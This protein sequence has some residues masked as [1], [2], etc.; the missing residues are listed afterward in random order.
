VVKGRGLSV[1]EW[2]VLGMLS[3]GPATVG[4]LVAATLFQQPTLTKIVDRMAAAGLVGRA[5]DPADGRRVV[6]TLTEDGRRIADELVP[7]AKEHE[8]RVLGGYAPG[9]AE[10]LKAA[11]RTLIERT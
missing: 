10:A 11:L 3:S 5:P 4:D 7:L 9:E 8:A 2:R 1:A 6:V